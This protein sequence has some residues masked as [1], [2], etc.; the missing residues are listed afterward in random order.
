MQRLTVCR[1][2][3]KVFIRKQVRVKYSAFYILPSPKFTFTR[4]S[5]HISTEGDCINELKDTSK[6]FV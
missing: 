1:G 6:S 4:F 2:F 5:T 3:I